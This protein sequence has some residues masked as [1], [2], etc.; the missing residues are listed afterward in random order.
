[1]PRHF[2]RRAIGQGNHAIR[3]GGQYRF[4]QRLHLRRLA[5]CC[6]VI[7]FRFK[8]GRQTGHNNHLLG[9]F[10]NCHCIVNQRCVRRAKLGI[11]ARRIKHFIGTERFAEQRQRRVNAGCID[12]RTAS[13]LKARRLGKRADKRQCFVFFEWQCR[14]AVFQQNRAFAGRFARQCVMG[15]KINLRVCGIILRRQCQAHN[16]GGGFVECG[17]GQRAIGDSG[18][19]TRIILAAT[20]RHFQFQPGGNAAWPVIHSPPIGHHQTLKPETPAQNI[21]KQFFMLAAINPV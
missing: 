12:L 8:Q 3:I 1:M 19:N 14:L 18:D 2:N 10:G 21:A 16:M 7:A 17:F 9:L 15:S 4:N 20:A 11:I 13:A 6:A 5:Q